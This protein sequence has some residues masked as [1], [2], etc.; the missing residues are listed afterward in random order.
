[1][2]KIRQA[3]IA[4][5]SEIVLITL[6]L[7]AIIVTQQ[8][9]LGNLFG[10]QP[11]YLG[12][13]PPAPLLPLPDLPL[14]FLFILIPLITLQLVRYAIS[15]RG[16][17]LV[18]ALIVLG[19][20]LS[21]YHLVPGFWGQGWAY[22]HIGELSGLPYQIHLPWAAGIIYGLLLLAYLVLSWLRHD[23]IKQ[24]T[25]LITLSVFGILALAFILR[26]QMLLA[27][28]SEVLFPD[29]IGYRSIADS[30]TSPYDTGSREPLWPWMIRL[31]FLIFGSAD[32]HVR[33]LTVF[34]ST[35]LLYVVYR[36]IQ[37]YIGNFWLALVTIFFLTIN[38][39][40]VFLSM[41]GLREEL[42]TIIIVMLAYYTL[43][44]SERLRPGWRI[45]GL[46][47]WA[48]LAEL[49]RINSFTFLLPLLLYA[50]WRHKLDW[51]KVAIPIA[52][53]ILFLAPHLIHNAQ[54]FGDPLWSANI[55]G[56]WYRNYEFVVV[57][58]TGCDGCPTPEMQ[59][60]GS[61]GGSRTTN[62]HYIFGMHPLTEIVTNTLQGYWMLFIRSPN[63]LRLPI[64]SRIMILKVLLLLVYLAGLLLLLWSQFRGVLLFPLLTINLIAFV[65]PIGDFD[66]RL[67]VQ[68]DPFTALALAYGLWVGGVV[69]P[70]V[71]WTAWRPDHH[72]SALAIWAHLQAKLR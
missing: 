13:N 20:E 52:A 24:K 30:M 51:R 37:S 7:I 11:P 57:K 65:V 14:F 3:W 38:E 33:M 71:I 8:G 67:A 15:R 53:V 64:G 28:K 72:L 41:G 5:R 42:Y 70:N 36:F 23:T 58:Q 56:I 40:L 61:Y 4:H 17:A 47:L 46:S 2:Q 16:W 63:V 29:V 19:A 60:Q 6:S 12:L 50:F 44:P 9:E 1:M 59:T 43:S 54:Q 68:V 55:Q 66:P 69:L 49:L 39:Y 18:A 26:W 62:F 31:W 27:N 35:T 25:Y 21:S 32:V 45:F 48:T 10:Y 22:V 34:L